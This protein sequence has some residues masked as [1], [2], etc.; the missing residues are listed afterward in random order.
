MLRDY[1]RRNVVADLLDKI[2]AL[3]RD[4]LSALGRPSTLLDFM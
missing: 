1:I 2:N 4:L 3:V